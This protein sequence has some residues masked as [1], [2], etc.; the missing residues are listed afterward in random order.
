MKQVTIFGADGRVGERAVEAAIRRGWRIKAVLHEAQ[1]HQSEQVEVI[2]ADVLNS[3][4]AEAVSGSEAVLS[5]LGV[6]NDL[7]TLADPPPL[8]TKGTLRIAS[9]MK[10]AGIDR[11][12]V[13]SASFVQTLDRGPLHFQ[14]VLPGLSLVFNQ[15]EQME[16]QLAR[17]SE[18]LRWTAVRPGW[19]MEGE[20]SSNAVVTED[21]IPEN[22]IRSRTSDIAGLMLD[23]IEQ[24]SWIHAR[25][26]IASPE[27]EEA[28]SIKA[29]A[30]E[31]L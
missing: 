31:I 13:V 3:D 11:L 15:M 2:E 21:V 16:A 1:P 22:L 27:N 9:A 14:A 23:C 6:G 28:T 25:P 10:K 19:I 17:Q 4:L 24:E 30:K 12:V 18:D 7:K 5:C 8:Y 20:A 29:V 26:A